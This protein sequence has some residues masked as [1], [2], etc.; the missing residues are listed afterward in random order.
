MIAL[1]MVNVIREY[2]FA[3]PDGAERIVQ[4]KH[5]QEIVQE[6]ENVLM[7]FV[8]VIRTLKES[9]VMNLR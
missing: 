8:Y 5:V 4:K 9:Y 2:V 7:E 6:M 1:D 3:I